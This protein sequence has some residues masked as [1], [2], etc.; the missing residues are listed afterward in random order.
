MRR[1]RPDRALGP[2]GLVGRRARVA[3]DADAQ[4]YRMKTLDTFHPFLDTGETATPD[5]RLLG[6]LLRDRGL[7]AGRRLVRPGAAAARHQRRRDVR[8]VGVLPRDRHVRRRTRRRTR[9]TWRSARD[10]RKGDL[11][12]LFDMDRGVEVLRMK[13]GA[14]HSRQMKSVTAP[15][16]RAS[17]FAAQPVGGLER[18]LSSDGRASATSARCSPEA[19]RDPGAPPCAAPRQGSRPSARS[20]SRCAWSVQRAGSRR[21]SGTPSQAA[22]TSSSSSRRPASSAA[23]IRRSRSSRCATYSSSLA[24]GVGRPPGRGRGGA[25]QAERAQPPQPVEVRR[26]ARRRPGR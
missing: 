23:R 22:S 3:V 13:K 24:S 10:R 19:Y 26:R 17:R 14:Y 5:A 18:N 2:D 11:L 1:E 4:P 8:Q 16:A 15:T 9:G 21:P 12:Y 25:A 20:F 6:A 7:D